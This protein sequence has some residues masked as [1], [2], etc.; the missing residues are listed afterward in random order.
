M[1]LPEIPHLP[2]FS[3]IV[4]Y[5]GVLAESMP[6]CVKWFAKPHGAYFFAHFLAKDELRSALSSDAGKQPRSEQ[7][8]AAILEPMP[9]C[10]GSSMAFSDALDR[11][12][13]RRRILARHPMADGLW[14]LP[15]APGVRDDE[16]SAR[17][18]CLESNPRHSL[19]TTAKGARWDDD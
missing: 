12:G 7:I 16:L 5:I 1:H 2:N 6:Q 17:R 8:P 13:K 10:E 19:R 4:G 11:S 14:Q 15:K 9:R 3:H 18:Q